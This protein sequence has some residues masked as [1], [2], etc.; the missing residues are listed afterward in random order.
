MPLSVVGLG[1]EHILEA[2]PKPLPLKTDKKFKFLHIS[3]CFPRKGVDVLLKAYTESFTNEDEVTLIIKTFPNPHNTIA[4]EIKEIQKSPNAPQII[5]INQD[6][7]DEHIAWLY[8]NSNCLVAPSRGEGFG[9]PMAEAMLFNLPVITTGFG[10]Q[11]DF[12]TNDTAWLIDYTFEKA[13]THLN[14]F[15]SYWAEPKVEDLKRLLTKQL[16]LTKEQKE[17][18]TKKAYY[19]ISTKFRWSDYRA[20][21]EAFIKELKNELV[22]EKERLNLGWVS[23]YNTKCGIASYSEFLLDNFSD[24]YNTTIFAN[25]T[26]EPIDIDKESS[27]IRCWENRFDDDNN[28]NLIKNILDKNISTVVINFNFGFFGIDNLKE[29]I[30]TLS[31]E[32]I[33]ITIIFHSVSDVTIKGLEASVKDIKSS[34]KLVNH[35]LVHTIDDLNFF[36]NMG[37]SHMALLPHGVINREIEIE[38]A[39]IKTIASYGF[40]LPHKGILELIE[41]FATLERE[42]PYLKLLLV[43]ALY[44]ADSSIAYYNKC[45]DKIE[46]LKLENKIELITDFLE[47]EESF[48]LLDRSNLVILPYHRTQESSSASVRFAIS[49]SKPVLCTPQ[50]IFDDVKDIVHFTKGYSPQEMAQSIAE[51]INNQALLYAKIVQ[52]RAWIEE[53]DWHH[54]A[55]RVENFLRR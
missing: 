45:K 33:K 22:F 31:K 38:E 21:T 15:N 25:Y 17:Q 18:K 48:K 19:L 37:F 12:C 52:Q 55:L 28:K 8:Q 7:K 46:E 34:L 5:L 27:V 43:N 53:H 51:L 49:L 44:P 3:S 35:L 32:N 16:T 54:I 39:E 26:K 4:D 20:K 29:I 11:S 36:K 2:T 6:L 42:Y 30:E 14:L 24:R 50:P 47:D 23:S 9:L 40:L 13:E 41:A 10:G 1:V